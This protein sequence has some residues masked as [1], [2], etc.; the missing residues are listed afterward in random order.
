MIGD[1]RA[2]GE[3]RAVASLRRKTPDMRFGISKRA[4]SA[5][6]GAGF[7]PRVLAG[8]RS[9]GVSTADRG[10]RSSLR[11]VTDA[12]E[13]RIDAVRARRRPRNAHFRST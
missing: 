3:A 6:R 11:H 7:R 8:G 10:P 2:P 4:R 5:K 9:G 13:M 1:A 12:I